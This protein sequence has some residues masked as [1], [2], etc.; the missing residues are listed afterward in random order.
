MGRRI[1]GMNISF[2]YDDLIEEFKADM[3]EG[4]LGDTCW[5]V[6][7]EE[8]LGYKPIIDYF[9]DLSMVKEKVELAKTQTVLDEML[10]MNR[11]LQKTL[12]TF[13]NPSYS[14]VDIGSGDRFY[15][16]SLSFYTQKKRC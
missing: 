5:I 12:D 14:Y 2:D 10:E 3:H 13:L 9:Y 7:G 4:L 8:Q 6:R 11:I 1:N 15:S 16:D